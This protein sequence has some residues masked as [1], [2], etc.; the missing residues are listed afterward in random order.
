MLLKIVIFLNGVWCV[1]GKR[2]LASSSFLDKQQQQTVV[3]L[4][5]H[6]H[7]HGVCV[8]GLRANDSYRSPGG[9]LVCAERRGIGVFTRRQVTVIGGGG[10]FMAPWMGGKKKSGKPTKLQFTCSSVVASFDVDLTTKFFKRS[11]RCL[12]VIL[13]FLCTLALCPSSVVLFQIQMI[14]HMYIKSDGSLSLS[15][16]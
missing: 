16:Q 13:L 11:S 1:P 3:T 15:T 6:T 5:T 2:P 8:C 14:G 12:F 9:S 10:A 4:H 7:T